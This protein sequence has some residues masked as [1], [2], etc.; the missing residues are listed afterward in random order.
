MIMTVADPKFQQNDLSWPIIQ[1]R[2]GIDCPNQSP[3][4]GY[5]C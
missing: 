2:A 1:I 4:G 5:S 3:I